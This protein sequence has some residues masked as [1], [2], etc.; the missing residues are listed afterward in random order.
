MLKIVLSCLKSSAGSR[1]F[2]NNRKCVGWLPRSRFVSRSPLKPRPRLADLDGDI[3]DPVLGWKPLQK[4]PQQRGRT[5]RRK[6]VY[7]GNRLLP[8]SRNPNFQLFRKKRKS[9]GR[10]EV[11]RFA[12]RSP[13]KPRPRLADF[14]PLISDPVFGILKSEFPEVR[15]S[16]FPVFSDT[17]IGR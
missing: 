10:L 1:N 6:V 9:A 3:S 7:I 15:I 4:S 12:G 8:Q 14:N 2:G 16:G 11:G 13:P 17:R 5:R